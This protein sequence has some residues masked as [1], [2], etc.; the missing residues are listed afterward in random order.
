[1]LL[2]DPD[3]NGQMLRVEPNPNKI[4]EVGLEEKLLRGIKKQ[5]GRH[6]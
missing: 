3:A 1:M 2:N 4:E 6:Q 5:L